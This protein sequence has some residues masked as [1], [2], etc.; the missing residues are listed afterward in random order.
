MW[1]LQCFLKPGKRD[2][3]SAEWD[4]SKGFHKPNKEAQQH[5]LSTSR[6]NRSWNCDR[7]HGIFLAFATP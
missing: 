2:L 4:A 1:I 7:S 5:S 6:E 3:N